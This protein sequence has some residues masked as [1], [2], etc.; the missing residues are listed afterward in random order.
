MPV[1]GQAVFN[2]MHEKILRPEVKP[3][4]IQSGWPLN[5]VI[6]SIAQQRRPSCQKGKVPLF[7][8]TVRLLVYPPRRNE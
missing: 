2:I 3:D 1:A 6:P 4:A 5:E 7:V 8:N